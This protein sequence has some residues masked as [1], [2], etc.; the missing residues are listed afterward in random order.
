MFTPFAFR[1][2]QQVGEGLDPDAQAFL[3][4][5]GITDPTITT[6]INQLVLD[7]KADS[8]WSK[9]I[10]IYPFVGGTATTHKYNLK[11]PRDLDAAYRLDIPGGFTNDS[12]GLQGDNTNLADSHFNASTYWANNLSAAL[13][14]YSP[15]VASGDEM[16]A[17]G[18][19]STGT[20]FNLM[21]KKY[22]AATAYQGRAFQH[23]IV[24][25]PALSPYVGLTTLSRNGS[26]S[27]VLYYGDTGMWTNTSTET[28]TSRPTNTVA[29][30]GL[31]GSFQR[32]DQT[33]SFAFI[34][35]G[36]TDTN[37]YDLNSAVQTFQTTLQRLDADAYAFLN[38]TGITDPT[39]V[40]AINNLVVSLKLAGVW[41]DC[42]AIYP[43]VGGDAT[44]H[45]YN[46][47]DTSTYQ[48]TW[49]GTVTHNSNGITG[50]GTDGYGNTGWN[51]TTAGRNTDGHISIYSRTDFNSTSGLMSDMGAGVSPSESLMALANSG[52]SYWI[53][54]SEV[55]SAAYGNTQ[56]LYLTNRGA[57]N[58]VGWKNSTSIS[59]GANGSGY[60]NVNLTICAQN[61]NGSIERF[62]TRNYA[63]ASMGAEISDVAAYYTAVQAFQLALGRQ[64]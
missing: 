29:V 2:I 9:M 63:F 36:L 31:N 34:S 18:G 7:L 27:L 47:K 37:V 28:S 11:D 42:D 32:T 41:N 30:G 1:T 51:Q 44:S 38:T 48:I 62:T 22:S 6:A 24:P 26:T 60:P 54:N 43:F 46:L 5:T 55:R 23:N 50:N 12:T 59:S 52:T 8:L 10:V 13:G 49:N 19:D 17:M 35:D 40:S 4:A 20:G 53:Y 15:D 21:S 16:I 57:S 45:S 39:I 3:T 25:S 14:F 61:R 58:T 33:F 56:G 64:V